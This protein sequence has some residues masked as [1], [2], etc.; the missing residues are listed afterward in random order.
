MRLMKHTKAEEATIATFKK[1]ARRL[2]F[3]KFTMQIKENR[4]LKKVRIRGGAKGQ[5]T[6]KGT[7]ANNAN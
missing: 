6:Q 4:E 1:K 3:R 7:A 5:L 2:S